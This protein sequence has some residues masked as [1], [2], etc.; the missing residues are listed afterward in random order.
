MSLELPRRLVES[1]AEDCSP[2]RKEWLAGLPD[3]VRGLADRM[4]GLLDLD[5]GRVRLWLFA[6]AVVECFWMRWLRPL[7]PALAP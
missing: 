2:E 7:L 5:A 1:V 3:V 4:A 6:R